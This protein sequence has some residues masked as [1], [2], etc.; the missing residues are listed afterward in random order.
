M[1]VLDDV[2]PQYGDNE[3]HETT[4]AAP[5]E[6]TWRAL[7]AVTPRELPMSR[8]LM[9]LR[10]LPLRLMRRDGLADAPEAPLL[11]QFL[12]AG[13]GTLVDEPPRAFVAGGIGQPWVLR[14]GRTVTPGGR[15]DFAAFDEP[16][17]LLMALSLE[18]TPE[19]GGS[20][21]RTETRVKPTDARAARSFRPY[22]LIVKPFSALIRRDLLRAIKRR[23][24]S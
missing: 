24:E 21:L 22:W 2:L 10:S 6:A 13:F 20:R 19:P 4:I 5:V 23:A 18:V 1:T 12:A 9:E 8:V 17:F 3:V 14:G 11:D 15:A 16:G 7:R